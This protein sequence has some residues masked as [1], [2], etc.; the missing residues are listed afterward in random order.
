MVCLLP[1]ISLFLISINMKKLLLFGLTLCMIGIIIIS[2]FNPSIKPENF[3][4]KLSKN[5]QLV[6]QIYLPKT[7]IKPYPTMILSH[8][9]NSSKET[10]TPLALELARNGIATIIPLLSL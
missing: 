2:Y 3:T 7:G 6:G 10:M 1:E 5:Q 4:V 9:I 8:G